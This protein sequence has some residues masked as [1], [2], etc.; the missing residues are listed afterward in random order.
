MPQWAAANALRGPVDPADFKAYIFPLLF[1]KRVCDAWEEEHEQAASD[2]DDLLDDEVEADYHR[3]LIPGGCHWADLRRI[4]ENVGV[5]LQ[6]ILDRL[7]QAN[8]ETLAGIF[9]DV[10]WGNKDVEMSPYS[11]RTVTRESQALTSHCGRGSIRAGLW[12]ESGGCGFEGDF[13]AHGFELG[14]ETSL[15]GRCWCV[16][17]RSSRPAP[18]GCPLRRRRDPGRR[19]PSSPPLALAWVGRHSPSAGQCR[20]TRLLPTTADDVGWLVHSGGMDRPATAVAAYR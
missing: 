20:A 9:G 13:V 5:G 12:P 3:F 8:P 10:A 7:Q 1:Y 17:R 6:R 19:Q 4:P 2:F 15:V 11:G 14:D 16:A 18:M